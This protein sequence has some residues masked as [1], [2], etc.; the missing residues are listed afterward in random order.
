MPALG[1]RVRGGEIAVSTADCPLGEVGGDDHPMVSIALDKVATFYAEQKKY[2]QA[3]RLQNGPMPSAP[4]FWRRG[5]PGPRRNRWRRI[6][7][8]RACAIPAGARGACALAT[9]CTRETRRPELEE[10]RESDERAAGAL[11]L[12]TAPEEVARHFS[13]KMEF[14]LDGTAADA[15]YVGVRRG[16]E[17]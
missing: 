5:C 17:G 14:D 1:R 6:T 15:G 7:R 3:R 16:R 10:E 2:D 12:K 4:I 9:A 11:V 13:M 8:T